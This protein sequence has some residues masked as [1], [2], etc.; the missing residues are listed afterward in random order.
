MHQLHTSLASHH[1]GA[2]VRVYAQR[3]VES[4][5]HTIVEPIPAR[6]EQTL[7]FQFGEGFGVHHADGRNRPAY[8]VNL[9]GANSRGG[10]EV[11]L[12]GRIVSFAIFFQPDGFSRLFGVPMA[13]LSDQ[14]YDASDVLGR[15]AGSLWDQ[16]AASPSF[17]Q[18]VEVT[19][20]FLRCRAIHAGYRDPFAAAA[21]SIFALRGTVRVGRI[22]QHC[23]VGIRHFERKFRQYSGI[24]PKYYA[25]VARFQT[26]LDAKIG[27]PGRSWLE[28]AHDLGYHDQMHLVHDFHDLAADAPGSVLAS[29][30]DMRP[31]A[32]PIYQEF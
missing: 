6:L 26:A 23:G 28:I 32:M 25:R 10:W 19:E 24:A 13:K 8:P 18:R 17:R 1:L 21:A 16:L 11:I 5:G 7:E 14:A 31:P 4:A 2:F 9:I 3:E 29:I 15:S 27:S 12:R 20:R 22:A 30:G